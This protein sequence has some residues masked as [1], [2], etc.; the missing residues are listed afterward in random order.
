MSLGDFPEAEI[1]Q[2]LHKKLQLF[3]L[4]TEDCTALV[5]IYTSQFNDPGRAVVLMC[6]SV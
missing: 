1:A 3:V 2:M 5:G 4:P 6:V